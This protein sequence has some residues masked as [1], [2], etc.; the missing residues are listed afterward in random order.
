M[1]CSAYLFEFLSEWKI[2]AETP[3]EGVE[4]TTSDFNNYFDYFDNYLEYF[5]GGNHNNKSG[6]G[7][8]NRHCSFSYYDFNTETRVA[9]RN[10]D[11]DRM[12]KSSPE[13]SSDTSSSSSSSEGVGTSQMGGNYKISKSSGK[14][15]SPIIV[16]TDEDVPTILTQEE[17][18][19]PASP[20][21]VI[22]DDEGVEPIVNLASSPIFVETGRS[23]R[24]EQKTMMKKDSSSY[25]TPPQVTTVPDPDDFVK[26]IY[27][28]NIG[29]GLERINLDLILSRTTWGGGRTMFWRRLGW[30]NTTVFQRHRP[31]QQSCVYYP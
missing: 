14:E 4:Y 31:Q 16:I 6:G 13:I 20:S 27:F 17:S 21:I 1:K 15:K 9:K 28:E 10:I 24:G 23:R 29:V 25:F 30:D 11:M 22:Y 12:S 7:N 18:T 8:Y 26:Q 2:A 3:N 5:G 19:Q